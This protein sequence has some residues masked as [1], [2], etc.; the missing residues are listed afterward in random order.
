[1]KVSCPWRPASLERPAPT[2]CQRRGFDCRGGSIAVPG[3]AMETS[4]ANAGGICPGFAGAV[5]CA[6]RAQEDCRLARPA[7][8]AGEPAA[9]DRLASVVVA[10]AVLRRTAMPSAFPHQQGSHA[11]ASLTTA[12][13][14]LRRYAS[15]PASLTMAGRAASCRYFGRKSKLDAAAQ[16]GPGAGRLRCYAIGWSTRQKSACWRPATRLKRHFTG[17]LHLPEDETGD[18]HLFTA[19]ARRAAA[20]NRALLFI[21]TR[22]RNG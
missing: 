10:S 11:G 17:G 13:P 1:M 22:L 3:A 19:G 2:I 16:A 18:C 15:R 21:L 7:R 8:S 12:R 20:K 4:F 14:A 9:D 6:G 5:G